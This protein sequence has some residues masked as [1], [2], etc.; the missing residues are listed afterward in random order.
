[1]GQPS[2][3]TVTASAVSLVNTQT[4]SPMISTTGVYQRENWSINRSAS[5]L[6]SCASSTNSIIRPNVE[7]SPILSATICIVPLSIMVPANTSSSFSVFI[8]KDSSVILASFTCPFPVVTLP[9][10]GILAPVFTM[11]ISP[12]STSSISTSSNCPSYNCL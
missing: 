11:R 3:N 7:S 12:S 8:G 4:N 6:E 10:T 2:T 9:S 1:P 5:D